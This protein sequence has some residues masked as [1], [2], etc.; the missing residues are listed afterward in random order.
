[1]EVYVYDSAGR[2]LE[3]F[4]FNAD[5]DNPNKVILH[6][7]NEKGALTET[8]ES[9]EQGKD[10]GLVPTT[11]DIFWHDDKG[12]V[13]DKAT[14]RNKQGLITDVKTTYKP[15]GKRVETYTY[16]EPNQVLIQGRYLRCRRIVN[17]LQHFAF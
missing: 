10:R 16:S 7:Y 15:N 9:V 4:Y 1:M 2:K 5:T 6:R 14:Y 12:R 17:Q 3:E 11:K 13:I 8:D